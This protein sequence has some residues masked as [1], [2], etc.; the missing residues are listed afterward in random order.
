MG[1]HAQLCTH[2]YG[3]S[4]QQQHLYTTAATLATGLD[5][6]RLQEGI[7]EASKLAGMAA[8][9]AAS[10]NWSVLAVWMATLSA[11]AA[12][13]GRKECLELLKVPIRAVFSLQLDPTSLHP[14]QVTGMSAAQA[15]ALVSA[16][17]TNPEVLAARPRE[18]VVAALS[19]M[20]CATAMQG[21]RRPSNARS[22]SVDG[23]ATGDLAANRLVARMA[24]TLQEAALRWV[25]ETAAEAS[26]DDFTDTGAFVR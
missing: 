3:G 10:A 22:K 25:R 18:D 21:N 17:I 24:A 26:Q 7:Q 16:G 8:K 6:V 13:Y 4:L 14:A 11:E 12:A 19:G 2:W 15:R 23:G 5:A 9:L 20:V 1:N